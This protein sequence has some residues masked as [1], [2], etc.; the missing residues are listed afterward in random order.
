MPDTRAASEALLAAAERRSVRQRG[1][2]LIPRIVVD[3]P[4]LL[5]RFVKRV[6]GATGSFNRERPSELW[7]GGRFTP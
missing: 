7:I 6:F 1:A 2:V 4:E 5:V 3:E